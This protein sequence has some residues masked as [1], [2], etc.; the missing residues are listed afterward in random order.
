MALLKQPLKRTKK[1]GQ[2]RRRIFVFR[3]SVQF[4]FL[5]CFTFTVP[6]SSTFYVSRRRV[7]FV[8]DF[9]QVLW[10]SVATST[11]WFFGWSRIDGYLDVATC[12]KYL[13]VEL[14]ELEL[15]KLAQQWFRIESVG[16]ASSASW[17]GDGGIGGAPPPDGFGTCSDPQAQ[18]ERK[19]R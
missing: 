3:L 1:V 9:R 6:Y 12:I 18:D 19:G 2:S 16:G 15:G 5:I 13:G 17:C 11:G 14:G 7:Q 10:Y 8:S 4:P